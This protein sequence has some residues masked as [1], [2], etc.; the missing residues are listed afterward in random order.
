MIKSSK[1]KFGRD[2]YI[3]FPGEFLVVKDEECILASVTNS[4]IV[5][6][7]F[8]VKEKIAGM[9]H[10]ILPGAL[11]TE[12]IAVDEI[13]KQGITDIEHIMGDIVKLK[14][15]RKRLRATFFGSLGSPDDGPEMEELVKNSIQF[16]REYFTMENIKVV[17][18]TISQCTQKITFYCPSGRVH[19][20]DVDAKKDYSEFIRRENE[21]MKGILERK[22]KYGKVILFD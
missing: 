16:L 21:Y 3:L 1:N 18:E 9:G 2:L 15:D 4:C 6:C 17:K 20:K 22:E 13:A 11:G 12:G 7:L 14:G 8:D 10:F 5:V 19:R